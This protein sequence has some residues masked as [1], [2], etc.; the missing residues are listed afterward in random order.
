M[1]IQEVRDLAYSTGYGVAPSATPGVGKP[2]L[3]GPILEP[4]DLTVLDNTPTAPAIKGKLLV[5][6]FLATNTGMGNFIQNTTAAI[7]LPQKFYGVVVAPVNTIAQPASVYPTLIQQVRIT[8]RGPAL[9]LVTT[10]ATPIAVGNPLVA[11]ALGNLTLAGATPAAGTVLG[12]AMVALA[13]SQPATLMNVLMG[14][15]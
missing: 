3:S 15:Y 12:Y 8:F 7:P 1:P 14:G 6:Q 2:F 4:D 5:T 9:A 11:D 13:A 10:G